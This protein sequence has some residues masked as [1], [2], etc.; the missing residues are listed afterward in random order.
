MPKPKE[1][2]FMGDLKY[3]LSKLLSNDV[4]QTRGLSFGVFSV[5]F[6]ISLFMTV[7]NAALGKGTLA[8]ITGAFTILGLINVLLVA[9]FKNSLAVANLLFSLETLLLF[10][11]FLISGEPDGFSAIWICIL[12]PIAMALSGKKMGS[13]FCGVMFLIL[14]FL[15]L[16]PIGQSLVEFRYTDTFRMRFPILFVAFYIV[17]LLMETLR[18]N[19]YQRM[20]QMQEFY[21]DLSARDPLTGML[22]RQGFYEALE[23]DKRFD[24]TQNVYVVLIDVDDFKLANDTYG[25]LVGDE[26]LKEFASLFLQVKDCTSCRWGGEEFVGVI[27]EKDHS[28]KRLEFIHRELARHI[29]NANGARFSV[30]AS[31]G[32]CRV[33]GFTPKMIEK[34]IENADH[35][36]YIAKNTGKNRIV[37]CTDPEKE[38]SEA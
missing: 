14:V 11:Y 10:T 28:A 7:V 1:G 2:V 35:A 22:N 25:H 16:T 13:V 18:V 8:I 15:L 9:F 19:A 23:S 6:L 5:L 4:S 29:Y 24:G 21:R 17:A 36:M 33:V 27:S 20:A 26:V 30:T 3:R 34:A 32:I 12:P 37:Y 38:E 31:I